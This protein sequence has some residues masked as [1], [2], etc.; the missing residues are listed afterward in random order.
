M[1]RRQIDAIIRSDP[2]DVQF[3]RRT[4]VET[5][6][7]GWKWVDPSTTL[8]EQTI[9]LIPFKRRMTEFLV[10]TQYGPVPDLPYVIVGR[11]DL[12]VIEG[13]TF[14]LN[15]Q[16][17]IVKTIDVKREIRTAGQVD[18]YGVPDA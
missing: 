7:G 11:Y 6:S 18:Y 9:T 4:K 15:G 17:F 14:S 13:D 10:D 2:S 8:P 5:A 3:I 12:D 16:Y 1:G